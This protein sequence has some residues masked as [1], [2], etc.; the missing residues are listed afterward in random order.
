M[1]SYNVICSFTFTEYSLF[2]H[3][4]FESGEWKV[5]LPPF[6]LHLLG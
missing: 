2:L 5:F 1:S 6:L 4:I 3:L